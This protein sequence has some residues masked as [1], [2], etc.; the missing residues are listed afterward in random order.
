MPP[1]NGF[2]GLK[3]A[4][5]AVKAT[6]DS[7]KTFAEG[8]STACAKA[9]DVKGTA[10]RRVET[11][12]TDQR[13]LEDVVRPKLDQVHVEEIAMADKEVNKY[14]SKVKILSMM[15]DLVVGGNQCR[16]S[17]EDLRGELVACKILLKEEVDRYIAWCDTV[18]KDTGLEAG[19]ADGHE[20]R[21]KIE[22]DIRKAEVELRAGVPPRS[23]RGLGLKHPPSKHFQY[24]IPIANSST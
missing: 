18:D 20:E 11:L 21:H 9:E 23:P 16:V 19:V 15:R 3:D 7:R 5:A 12:Q 22:R 4:E 13:T 17:K 8:A 6:E 1:G 14:R 2:Q 24:L 10:G